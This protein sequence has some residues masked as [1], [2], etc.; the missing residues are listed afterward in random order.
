M[1]R[2]EVM[3]L[4]IIETILNQ[5]VNDIKTNVKTGE[6]LADVCAAEEH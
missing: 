5:K 6:K 3:P 4:N 1:K 2:S